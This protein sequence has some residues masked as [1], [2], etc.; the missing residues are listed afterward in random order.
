[1]IQEDRLL[2]ILALLQA[3][4]SVSVNELKDSLYVSTA[5]VRRDLQEL[6]RRGLIVRSFGGAV[7]LTSSDHRVND[8]ELDISASSPIA[9]A[10]AELVPDGSCIFIAGS[11]IGRTMVPP[12]SEKSSLRVVTDSLYIS[13][14]L[15]GNIDHVCCTGG[16][17]NK[18]QGIFTGSCAAESAARYRYDF[19]FFSFDA[20]NELGEL[21]DQCIEKLS[22]FNAVKMRCKNAVLLAPGSLVNSEAPVILASLSDMDIV[23]TDC[24]DFFTR[25]FCGSVLGV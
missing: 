4:Q 2:K 15:C 13:A 25:R 9:V 6:S 18:A 24:P 8:D 16:S 11:A 7:A 22:V 14:A 3:R 23:V 21:S 17:F 1:M 20:V 10:A 19:A 5:T 12:L